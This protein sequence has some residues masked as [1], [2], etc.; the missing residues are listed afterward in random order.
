MTPPPPTGQPKTKDA[1]AASNAAS[2]A[3]L[4][5]IALLG[6]RSLKLSVLMKTPLG[7]WP[8]WLFVVFAV[9]ASFLWGAVEWRTLKPLLAR[10]WRVASEMGFA[11]VLG[12]LASTLPLLGSIAL[13]AYIKPIAEWLRTHPEGLWIYLA[14]F[15]VLG[16]IALLPTYAQ[17]ALGGFAF[18]AAK[19]IPLALAGFAGAALLG[20]WIALRASPER[21][22][23]VVDRDVRAGAVRR[24]LVGGGFM[25]QTGIVTLLRLPPTSPFALTNLVLAAAG[26]RL[27]PFVVGTI[28]G[29]APRTVVAVII[30]A[31]VQE[32]TRDTLESAAPKWVWWAGIA[33]SIAVLV[34]IMLVA[35]KALAGVLR[36]HGEK[37][38]PP[39]VP[40]QQ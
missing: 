8:L 4:A 35:K 21:V 19:G 25:R 6:A 40:S 23:K 17:S 2:I 14:G 31:G 30:G 38:Q 33:V 16:G 28:I 10:S 39:S 32:L 37:P 12:V 15:V 34:V 7:E 20:Y 5:S 9:A 11:A 18:G 3:W 36:E 24:A 1:S 27:A 29:M 13:Y 26:V 22:R